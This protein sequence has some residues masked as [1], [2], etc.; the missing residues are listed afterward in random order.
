M[1]SCITKEYF[2]IVGK[3]GYFNFIFIISIKNM[4]SKSLNT[5]LI[6]HLNKKLHTFRALALFITQGMLA[7]PYVCVYT[8]CVA[9]AATCS[10]QD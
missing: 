10:A 1:Y 4:E 5:G 6:G 8:P 7:W 9:D 2:K 3:Q